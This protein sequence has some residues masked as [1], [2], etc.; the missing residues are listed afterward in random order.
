MVGVDFRCSF[1]LALR[2][3][4]I[5]SSERSSALPKVF[6]CFRIHSSR[7]QRSL[8]LG[9]YLFQCRT[10]VVIGVAHLRLQPQ[11]FLKGPD[12]PFEVAVLPQGLGHLMVSVMR[13]VTV[14]MLRQCRLELREGCLRPTPGA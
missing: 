6:L 5:P 10:E 14:R 12:G 11:R 13:D 2:V 7:G 3:F 1:Q 4:E 9:C 8:A